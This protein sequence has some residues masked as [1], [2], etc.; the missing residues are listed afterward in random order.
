MKTKRIPKVVTIPD[1][2]FQS[3]K[4]RFF[5]GQSG[6]LT[7]SKGLNAWAGLINPR[8]SRINIVFDIFAVS[9]FSEN[10]IDAQIF[11]N[12]IPPD[13]ENAVISEN[14]TPANTTLCPLSAPRTLVVY[15]DN[16]TGLPV[17]GVSPFRRIIPSLQ[18]VEGI[19]NGKIMI[20]PG[21]SF[22]IFIPGMADGRAFISFGWW[23]KK[24][25][26]KKKS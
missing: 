3:S 7:I 5:I 12:S 17:G 22:V 13:I 2:A 9:N 11:F 15:N 18:T 4:G 21:G 19:D 20:P 14:V 23:E 1:S 26:S 25:S 8:N 24:I 6:I 16:V 10:A